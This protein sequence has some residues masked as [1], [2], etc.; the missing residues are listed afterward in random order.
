MF[1]EWARNGICSKLHSIFTALQS[2][3]MDKLVFDVKVLDNSVRQKSDVVAK[4]WRKKSLTTQI[5][6]RKEKNAWTD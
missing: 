3:N 6:K 4:S 5:K 1:G 2:T